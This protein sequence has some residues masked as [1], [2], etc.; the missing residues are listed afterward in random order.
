MLGIAVM[1]KSNLVPIFSD[2]NA[3]EVSRM[4]RG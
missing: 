3:V 1:H 4:R 2:D